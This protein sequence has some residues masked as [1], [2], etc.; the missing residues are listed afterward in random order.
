MKHHPLVHHVNMRAEFMTKVRDLLEIRIRKNAQGQTN[1]QP[2]QATTS[3][4]GMLDYQ[5]TYDS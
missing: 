2:A 3:Y 1:P 5:E 4:N